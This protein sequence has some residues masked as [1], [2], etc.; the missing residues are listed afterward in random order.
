MA[1]SYT[2]HRTRGKRALFWLVV[3][4][5]ALALAESD[6]QANGGAKYDFKMFP[7]I[8]T[9][10]TA[11]RVTFSAPFRAD[12]DA[13]TYELEAVGPRGCPSVYEYLPRKGALSSGLIRRGDRVVM[14]LTPFDDLYLND[15][16]TWCRGSYVGYVY[17]SGIESDRRIGYFR[18][19][20]GRSPASLEP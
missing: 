10:T 20:V 7:S 18:F 3:L 2:T 19:G 13:T 9:P 4:G 16:R 15:C 12:G 14:R 5:A 1:R 17:Y 11:F 6:S 8:G